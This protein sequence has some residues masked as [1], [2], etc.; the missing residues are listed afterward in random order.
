MKTP[1]TTLDDLKKEDLNSKSPAQLIE[2]L[3]QERL[4]TV[5]L[6][7]QI[8]AQKLESARQKRL[9]TPQKSE[10]VNGLT[11]IINSLLDINEEKIAT[12]LGKLTDLIT[13]L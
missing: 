4:R 6:L 13:K 11:E 8:N 9:M 1:S 5:D 7:A 12:E 10:I 2:L 3:T